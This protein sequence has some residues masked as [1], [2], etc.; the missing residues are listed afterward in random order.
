[1]IPTSIDGTDITGATID[2][3][4]VQEITVDGQTVFSATTPA[5]AAAHWTFDNADT[6][7]STCF[8]IIGNLDGTIDGCA[9]GQ[10]GANQTYTT[11]ESYEFDGSND[12]IDIPTNAI[13][14]SQPW[15]I[16][17]WFNTDLDHNGVIYNT[18]FS[19]NSR[20][21]QFKKKDGGQIQLVGIFTASGQLNTSN[22]SNNQWHHAVAT[23][24]GANESSIYIDG[25]IDVTDTFSVNTSI[26]SPI[27]FGDVGNIGVNPYN[28]SLDD[29]R[30]YDFELTS[31]QVN[32]LYNTGN[33]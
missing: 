15:S 22:V 20:I 23:Y 26:N 2:G 27:R 24:N 11:N 18:D 29:M 12:H 4:D 1:M 33:V 13:D 3:T 31:T 9:T 21:F 17:C 25:N 28:G 6:S 5:P 8:D 32:N 19:S 30:Y 7:G 16:A 14:Y 10:S